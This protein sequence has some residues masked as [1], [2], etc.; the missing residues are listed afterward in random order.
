MTKPKAKRRAVQLPRNQQEKSDF[1]EAVVALYDFTLRK[2]AG[3]FSNNKYD[4]FSDKDQLDVRRVA[5]GL[6]VL[7][8][9]CDRRADE[10]SRTS[11]TRRVQ[12]AILDAFGIIDALTT[13]SNHPIRRHIS[14]LNKLK[15]HQRAPDDRIEQSRRQIVVG[16]IVAYQEA[17]KVTPTVAFRTVWDFCQTCI[18]SS[19]GAARKWVSRLRDDKGVRDFAIEI[20]AEAQAMGEPYPLAGIILTLGRRRVWELWSVPEVRS[21]PP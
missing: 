11:P 4:E 2:E 20:T 15:Y 1:A 9:G 8:E 13:G 19:E 12:S 18:R 21:A 7:R 10:L 5:H 3:S 16:L 6:V 17:A 14:S